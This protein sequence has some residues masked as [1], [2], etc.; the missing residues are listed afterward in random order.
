MVE[1]WQLK[2]NQLPTTVL[3]PYVLGLV[4]TIRVTRYPHHF[5]LTLVWRRWERDGTRASDSHWKRAR[6]VRDRRRVNVLSRSV[7]RAPWHSVL[8]VRD[9]RARWSQAVTV[10]TE[11]A[12]QNHD[13]GPAQSFLRP[14]RS[15]QIT[16][17]IIIHLLEFIDDLTLNFYA[18]FKTDA[19]PFVIFYFQHTGN[20]NTILHFLSTFRLRQPS[21]FAYRDQ[22]SLQ[23]AII[24]I[25]ASFIVNT[26]P[27]W[28]VTNTTLMT[29][30]QSIYDCIHCLYCWK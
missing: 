27:R 10:T 14:R 20:E 8:C 5:W 21:N 4:Y 18:L 25:T 26:I 7:F 15:C 28:T 3:S 13:A 12:S 24:A 11:T 17:F 19:V 16:P 30:H 22:P 9:G 29:V 23:A 6:T 2:F 1:I